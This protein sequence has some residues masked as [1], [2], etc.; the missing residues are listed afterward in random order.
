[1][2]RVA[3]L[4]VVVLVWIADMANG[5][6]DNSADA[7]AAC[8]RGSLSLAEWTLPELENRL[9]EIADGRAEHPVPVSKLSDEEIRD[10]A[11]SLAGE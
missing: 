3:V 10:I 8:H 4:I 9:R 5:N 11:N 7:C 2:K 1:M 6:A